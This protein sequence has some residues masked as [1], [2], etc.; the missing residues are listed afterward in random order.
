MLLSTHSQRLEHWLGKD[1]ID[2]LVES[3]KDWYGPPIAVANVPG[4]VYVTKGGDFR[5][6]IEAGRGATLLDVAY[7]KARRLERNWKRRHAHWLAQ[8]QKGLQLNTGFASLSDLLAEAS[9]GKRYMNVMQKV[10]TTGVVGATNSLWRVG[11][12]PS[13]G[14]A[15][16]AA[17]GGRTPTD[18]TTGAFPFTN[19]SGGD[20]QY[21]VNANIIANVAGNQLLLYDRIFDVLKTMNSTATEAVTGVP[22]RY[23]S[24]TV[25]AEDWIGGNFLFVECGTALAATAHNWTTCT[26]TDQGNNASTLPSLTGNSGNI[27]NR[28]DHPV[29]QWFAPLEAG[30]SGIKALTQMQCS[31]A[32]ATGAIDFVIGH[33]IGWI[34]C[35]LANILVPTDA[36][37]G[38]FQ[39]QRIFDDACLAFLEVI[40]SAT[41]ATT[42]AG[43]FMS[44]AG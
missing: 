28:I 5:G 8:Q 34:A 23:Q 30:D 11:N 7:D 17:P 10:G 27:I 38:S 31:A 4:N 6:H 9:A 18:V 41:G 40:K 13:A 21:F 24:T 20:T 26:Y 19:P 42:Y 14:A 39:L 16:S 3:M 29:N 33:P 36:I 25:S 32:V 2:N 15:A 22:T 44:V 12:Q 35:P 43:T 37:A 1:E